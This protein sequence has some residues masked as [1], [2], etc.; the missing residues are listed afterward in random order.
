VNRL[1]MTS[2]LSLLLLA[3]TTVL[4]PG[5]ATPPAAMVIPPVHRHIVVYSLPQ[6]DGFRIDREHGVLLVRW[7]SGVYAYVLADG[8]T[9]FG[10]GGTMDRLDIER[11]GD[12]VTVDLGARYRRSDDPEAWSSAMILLD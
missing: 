2:A 4:V 3:S 8:V 5:V 9:A 7:R 6:Q 1:A 11:T 12:A 10:S